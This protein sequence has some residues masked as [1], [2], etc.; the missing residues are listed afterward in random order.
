[1][2]AA[3]KAREAASALFVAVFNGAI[4]LGALTGGR[5]ADGWGV[6]GVMGLGGVLAVGALVTVGVGRAPG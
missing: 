4:A 1:M 6:V 5:A 2:A 3:P